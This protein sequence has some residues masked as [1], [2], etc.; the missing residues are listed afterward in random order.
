MPLSRK[1]RLPLL[2]ESDAT[3]RTLEIYKEIKRALGVPHVNLIFQAYGAHPRVL[4]LIWEGM[5]PCVATAEFFNSDARIGAEAYTRIHNYFRVIG[6]SEA[7]FSGDTRQDIAGVVDL[8]HY[9]NPLLLLITA[10]QLQAFENGPAGSRSPSA[11]PQHPVFSVRPATVTEEA[12]PAHI[13]KLYDDIKRTLGLASINTDYQAFAAWPDFLNAY[14]SALKPAVLS[15][16]YPENKHA[17]RE[18]A[19]ALAGELPESP[20]LSVE[21]MQQAGLNDDEIGAAIHITEEF[22]DVLSGLVLNIAFA[23]IALEGGNQAQAP[24][25]KRRDLQPSSPNPEP[26]AEPPER[27]A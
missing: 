4:E 3:G 21:Q 22:L 2:R 5:Q 12:A 16:L 26:T 6:L 10:T 17:M 9:N 18:S 7:N 19:I 11:S 20:Q 13:R 15:P 27:A 25:W 14:W 8:F 1:R 24:N 23:K